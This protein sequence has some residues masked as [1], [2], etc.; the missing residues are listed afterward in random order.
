MRDIIRIGD[1]YFNTLWGVI[2]TSYDK[3]STENYLLHV[4]SHKHV[5][6]TYCKESVYKNSSLIN[7]K[8]EHG[9]IKEYLKDRRVIEYYCPVCGVIM[10]SP[11]ERRGL[12]IRKL[13]KNERICLVCGKIFRKQRNQPNR[14]YCS[15]K[16][17]DIAHKRQMRH[18]NGLGTF[19]IYYSNN[20][21]LSENN[22]HK[23]AE[24][25][26][27]YDGSNENIYFGEWSTDSKHEIIAKKTGYWKGG[28]VNTSTEYYQYDD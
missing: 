18:R 8:H 24:H 25:V 20:N 17:A 26:R 10:E 4:G 2:N 28:G 15:P 5:W 9:V 12:R 21:S 27:S 19:L 7:C 6:N 11:K 3:R 1:L 22:I 16:C 14:K 23:M 13:A